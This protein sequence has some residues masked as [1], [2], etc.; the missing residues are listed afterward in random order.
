[1]GRLLPGDWDRGLADASEGARLS[2]ETEQ[3]T[4]AAMLDVL[5]AT[6]AAL[7][8]TATASSARWAAPSR[9]ASAPAPGSS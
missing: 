5:G 3:P 4:Y 6:L 7:R 1:V 2:R 9:S 8:A